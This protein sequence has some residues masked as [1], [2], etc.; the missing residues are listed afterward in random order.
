[1]LALSR[2]WSWRAL[3][4]RRMFRAF[5]LAYTL[6]AAFLAYQVAFYLIATRFG[7][8]SPAEVPYDEI[9]NGAVPW[10]AV[11]FA[12]F[13]P[14]VSDEF[15]SRAFSIPFFERVF[16]SRIAAIVISGFIWGFGHAAYPN[17]PFFIR[18]LEVGF[19][20][21]ILGF[22]MYRFGVLPLIMWHFTIDALY[23]ALLLFRSG[24]RYYV[25][26][27]GIA[28][29]VFAIPMLASIAMYLKNGGFAPDDELTN[30]SVGTAPE[31]PPTERPSEHQLPP[32]DVVTSRRLIA[33]A[34]AVVIAALLVMKRPASID[35][36]IDY[37]QPRDAAV[38]LATK[39][40]RATTHQ[41]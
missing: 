19:A 16:R 23:T 29:L 2:I 34:V 40:L 24:N 36:A 6:T 11:L 32:A 5:V 37:Q 13:L 30:A 1:H 25:I 22:L 35:D 12:G 10:I 3:E 28:S 8:W 7:A 33:C 17:Q 14:G 38:A 31:L 15:M 27:A 18:G 39:H 4:S 21:V 20:G 9:L 41:P 26:S